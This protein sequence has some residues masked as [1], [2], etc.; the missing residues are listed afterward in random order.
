[1]SFS[2]LANN[3]LLPQEKLIIQVE[4]LFKQNAETLN[5]HK[6]IE[7]SKKIINQRINYPSEIVAKTYLLLANVASNKGELETAIQFTNDGLAI[8]T[9][10]QATRLRLQINLAK[11]FSAKKQYQQLLTTVQKAINTPQNKKYTAS[12]LI[13]LGYRSVA[14]AMLGQHA[15]A[16][17]DLQ[18]VEIV[19]SQ[20]PAFSEYI[21]LLAILANAY[22]HLGD[23][24][25]A[26]TVQLRI[27]KLRFNLNILNNIDQT[28]FHLANTYYRLNRFNDAYTTY[29]ESK[30]YAIKK[31][32]PIYVGYASQGLSLTLLRQKQYDAAKTEALK[33]NKLFYQHNLPTPYLESMIIL[34]Q[35]YHA[36]KQEEQS[37]SL[38]LKAEKLVI[39]IKLSADY[40]I[41]YKY[42]A[43]MYLVKQDLNKAYLWKKKYSDAL[44][45]NILF[46]KKTI[47]FNN[48]P[49]SSEIGKPHKNKNI[50]ASKKA[51]ELAIKLAEQSELTST[52][53][54]KFRKQQLFILI[55][56][57]ITALLL[58]FIVILR[59]KQRRQRLLSE[60]DALEKPSYILAN[61]V[62]T[63]QSYQ[64]NFNMARKYNYPLTLGYISI[65]NWQELTFQF[66]KKTV[67]EVSRG[68]ARLI[69]EQLNEF[70]NS[71]IINNGEY[72]LFF[73]HQNKE[74]VTKTI[75]KLV[76]TLK[77][78]YFANLGEFSVLIAY[79]IE[80]PDFQ[81]IDP[82]IFLSQLSNSIKLA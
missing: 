10:N 79:S 16:L 45:E 26:L 71:G 68:I 6:V 15:K 1:M 18:Q 47:E 20:N 48:Y 29:W 61:P 2:T 37:F 75:E 35:I 42:L 17:V 60:Y 33:A 69:N 74:D 44:L 54:D 58:I 67:L 52:F 72:L 63:K 62:Q 76:S 55:S 8:A 7:I 50:P 22:Y 53:S 11:I 38:L 23:Y 24:R 80:S 34:I 25:T 19:I 41:F 36:I 14:F 43:D 9:Q 73:P 65:T 57:I 78:R 66:N 13:A 70:E 59:V 56:T 40:I 32:A 31:E 82:Y 77:L 4:H 51:R 21:S 28:Y 12:F 46:I 81:D 30:N 5:Y 3:N 39:N 27:L 64:A 49:V